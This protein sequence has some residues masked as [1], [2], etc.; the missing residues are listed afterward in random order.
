MKKESAIAVLV[1][2]AML[3]GRP[4]PVTGQERG[5]ASDS[6]AVVLVETL[7]FPE[8][9]AVIVR[10]AS[11]TPQD[12]ILI[13]GERLN[14]EQ[15]A[16]ALIA[17]AGLR[18]AKGEVIEEDQTFR[19]RARTAPRDAPEWLRMLGHVAVA[20]VAMSRGRGIRVDGIE[21]VMGATRVALARSARPGG[22]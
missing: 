4:E 3:M 6:V 1:A 12:V 14:A 5:A 18:S 19:V 9:P 15:V 2:T 22:G 8:A 21:G 16:A 10:R 13:V 7:P 11:Q 17:L 20:E